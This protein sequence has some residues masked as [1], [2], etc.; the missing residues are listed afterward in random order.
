MEERIKLLEGKID[1]LFLQ[2]GKLDQI[3]GVLI[4]WMS[5]NK[6]F[7]DT[8]QVQKPTQEATKTEPVK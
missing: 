1:A 5:V 4:T 2:V 8:L 7:M 6:T 3:L